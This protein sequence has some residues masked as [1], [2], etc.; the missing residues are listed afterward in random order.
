M[1]LSVVADQL[2]STA[3]HSYG[4]FQSVVHEAI[5][6]ESGLQQI[7]FMFHLS[8]AAMEHVGKGTDL[9]NS[10]KNMTM[11]YFEQFFAPW[12]VEQGG[13]VSFSTN[14]PYQNSKLLDNCSC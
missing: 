6:G 13:W 5:R 8:R 10:I 4:M 7:A 2:A 9:A 1:E 12:L 3:T 11:R 14:L